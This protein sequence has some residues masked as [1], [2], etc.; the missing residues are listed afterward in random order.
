MEEERRR[1]CTSALCFVRGY[2]DHGCSSGSWPWFSPR[3]C[4]RTS[5]SSIR[6]DTG[7]GLLQVKQSISNTIDKPLLTNMQ[8]SGDKKGSSMIS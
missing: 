8:L 6:Y 5:V 1:I 2:L 4:C 7:R 3:R